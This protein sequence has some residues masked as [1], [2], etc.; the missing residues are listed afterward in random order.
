MMKEEF[1]RLTGFFPTAEMYKVIEKRYMNFDG[2]KAD[3]CKA[4][5]RNQ[6][7]LAEKIQFEA[8]K[9]KYREERQKEE[10]AE[11]AEAEIERLKAEIERMKERL[12]EEQEW[13][14][15]ECSHMDQERYEK[16]KR[17]GRQ[18]TEQEATEY[19]A[20]EFGFY[21]NRIKVLTE[22]PKYQVNR[23]SHIRKNGTVERFPVYDATDWN[24]IR[25]DCNGW[26]YEVVNGQLYQ[27]CD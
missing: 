20:E 15:S 10:A 4:F 14:P 22:I 13:K 11:K 18:M 23:H 6:N 8:D 7:G 1:E 25:F 3:F 24:Y 26:Q 5:K 27:Y 21:P 17:A 16:L 12:D 2:D 9:L 19:I